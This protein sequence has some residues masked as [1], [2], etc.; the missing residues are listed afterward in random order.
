MEIKHYKDKTLCPL[1]EKKK[2]EGLNF[3]LGVTMNTRSV[4]CSLGGLSI[5][6]TRPQLF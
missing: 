3:F 5:Q 1:S 4:N 6:S 2:K